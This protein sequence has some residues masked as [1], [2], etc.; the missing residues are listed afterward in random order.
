MR[1]VEGQTLA[2]IIDSLRRGDVDALAHWPFPRRME[3]FRKVLDAVVNPLVKNYGIPTS[4]NVDKINQAKISE[5][6]S[7]LNS[8]VRR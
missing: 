5:Y 2:Q 1:H 6:R 3:V 7:N 8:P 4:K